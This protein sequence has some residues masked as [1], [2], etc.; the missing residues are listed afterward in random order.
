VL[1]GF[2]TRYKKQN[3]RHKTEGG[4]MAGKRKRPNGWE[5]VFKR[6]GVLDKP[7]YMT[8]ASEEEGDAYAA[9][10]EALLDR[11]IVPTEHQA[12]NKITTLD[13]LVSQYIR[14]AHPKPKDVAA[15]GTVTKARGFT[16]LASI[17]AGWVDDWITELKRVDKIAP[18]TIR[19]KVG[20][21]AR[22]TDWGMRKG[23]LLMPD[24]PLR[25][26]PDGYAQYTPTDAAF[27]GGARTD[28]ERDRRLEPGEY[29]RILA[30]IDG[31]VLHRKQRPLAIEHPDALRCMFILAVESAMRMREM[32]TL[33][34]Q[35]V[36][37]AK[38]TVFLEKTKNGSKR[39]VPM[40][41]VAKSLL[42]ARLK[43][44]QG[45]MLF[46]WVAKDA[47][48]KTLRD[49]S[50]YLSKLYIGIFEQAGCAD[51]KF[52][53]LR[54]HAVSM[55]FERTTLSDAEIM[56]VVGHKSMRMMLRYANLRGA[57]LAQKLWSV[58]IPALIPFGLYRLS[59]EALLY[60]A[61]V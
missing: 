41:S 11:G 35:Q 25:T 32:Y 54:H 30:V 21:L 22:C 50:D 42:E 26:L 33:T 59:G 36:D 31:G 49:T 7:L 47:N 29:E 8:F 37:I 1:N 15:L 40:S 45:D 23:L 28:V 18:A 12:E 4:D 16:H 60:V 51:L 53:D 9:R 61:W 10:L 56:K 38:R 43:A 5:Y 34:V 58:L 24:H 3:H 39:Q 48:Q 13:A 55:L 2:A 27:A 6:A 44:V 14:D 46:P 52:H 20:A 19:A 57:D 17:N